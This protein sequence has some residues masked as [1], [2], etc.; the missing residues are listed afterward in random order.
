MG[1]PGGAGRRRLECLPSPPAVRSILERPRHPLLPAG[2]ARVVFCNCCVQG[3][4]AGRISG[5]CTRAGSLARR[6]SRAPPPLMS[7]RLPA[8]PSHAPGPS[9]PAACTV[10]SSQ[11]NSNSARVG[12]GCSKGAGRQGMHRVRPS[13]H[14]GGWY[15]E[16]ADPQRR[17]LLERWEAATGP[18]SELPFALPMSPHQ[19]KCHHICAKL[20]ASSAPCGASGAC[21]CGMPRERHAL[22]AARHGI[23]W[24][25]PLDLLARPQTTFTLQARYHGMLQNPRWHAFV[26][27]GNRQ[28][29]AEENGRA[30]EKKRGGVKCVGRTKG[31]RKKGKKG[32]S[33]CAARAVGRM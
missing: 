10:G 23:G 20:L 12:A 24:E 11:V 22:W 7:P 6:R 1:Q 33:Y 27:G 29:E 17:Q 31:E 9:V 14:K 5:N 26:C 16:Q 21:L 25:R 3:C 30:Q 18:A 15:R 8:S 28:Q 2:S 13:S 19:V 32:G 4:W